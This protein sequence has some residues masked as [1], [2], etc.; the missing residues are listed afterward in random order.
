VRG[1]AYGICAAFA[2]LLSFSLYVA[3]KTYDGTVEEDYY[4]RSL[5]YFKDRQDAEAGNSAWPLVS[6]INGERVLLDI[7]PK[8]VRAMH[9]L[10]FTVEIP[11]EPLPGTPWI[12]IAMPGMTMP[13]NRVDLSADGNGRYRGKGM[14]V[15]CPSGMRSW[16]ASVH[17]PGKGKA[18]FP[19]DAAD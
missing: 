19:F 6:S 4:R 14:V 3:S 8:P 1:L 5:A 7:S 2:V 11:G 17:V 9:E 12:E 13:P 15:R 10:V 16:T 18:L